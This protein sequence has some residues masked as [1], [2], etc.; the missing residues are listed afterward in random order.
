MSAA[1]PIDLSWATKRWEDPLSGTE[2]VRLS[3]ATDAHF[4]NTYFRVNSFTADGRY[5][6]L[7]SQEEADRGP[8][9]LWRIDL[10]TGETDELGK[11]RSLGLSSWAVSYRS[12]LLHVIDAADGRVEIDRIDLDT[13]EKRR[14]RPS[15][16]LASISYAI[17]S[18]D[19]RHIYTHWC[20]KKRPAGMSQTEYIAMMGSEPGRNVMYR[21]DLES[22]ATEAV[23][24]CDDWWIGHSNPNPADPDL[25]MCCQE[26]F[27]WTERY[28]RPADFQRVRVYDLK[29]GEWLD[30]SRRRIHVAHEMWSADGRRI[31][32]HSRYCGHH[33]FGL[34]NLDAGNWRNYVMPRGSGESIHVHRA[35]DESFLVGDGHN[36]GRNNEHEAVNLGRR[37]EGDNPFSYDGVGSD[38]PGEVIWKYEL[39]QESIVTEGDDFD[40]EEELARA[41]KAHPEK[42]ITVAPFCR[43]RSRM[44]MVDQPIRLESNAQV[45]PDSRWTVFQSCSEDGLHEV[46]A[47]HV[48]D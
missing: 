48:R 42:A 24:E 13:G 21:V 5:A 30:L 34:F 4:R 44:K 14:I 18:A 16:P 9:R 38:S 27:I 40:A 36:F 33:L 12:H 47:A 31:Y 6:V 28:P 41:I 10:R 8:A 37:G 39:P 17:S 7:M 22:G 3:P 29:R 11:Y 20:E 35:P 23:F 1:E 46:W 15:P 26:G 32:G 25:F 19:D 45:T 2:V 43:F